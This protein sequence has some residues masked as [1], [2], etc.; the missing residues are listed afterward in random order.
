MAKPAEPESPADGQPAAVQ[1]A[2]A[3]L[4]QRFLAGLPARWTEISTA[5][6][7]AAR[8]GALHRLAGAAGSYGLPEL[9]QAARQA[10]RAG[11]EP[12]AVAALAELEASLRA[13]GVTVK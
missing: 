11:G 4:R 2:F 10:E 1:A 6:G 7:A 5:Q 3:V 9:S 12:D 8:A 13:H